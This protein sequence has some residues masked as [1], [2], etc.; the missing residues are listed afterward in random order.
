MNTLTEGSERW[1]INTEGTKIH[2]LHHL[3]RN[4]KVRTLTMFDVV[5]NYL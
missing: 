2:I 4:M 1:Q 5:S 3:F